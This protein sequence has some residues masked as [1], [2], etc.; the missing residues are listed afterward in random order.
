[1]L[2]ADITT[3]GFDADD[4]LWQ[5]E[6]LFKATEARFH[7]LLAGHAPAE[8]LGAHLLAVEKRNIAIYGFG[9]KGFM[10]SMIET[11]LE[12]TGGDLPSEAVREILHLGHAMLSH[13]VE[14]L[15]HVVETLE[16]LAGRVRLVLITKGDLTD[17]ERKLRQSG[18][19]PHFS[20]VE[21]VSDKSAD[22]YRR[23][24]DAYG[25][26]PAQ[27]LMVGN[28]L[29]SDILPA[30]AAGAYAMHVP[31]ELTWAYEAHVDDH[32]PGHPRFVSARDIR[33]VLALVGGA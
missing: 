19:A 11:A 14:M 10:L 9:V 7:E 26:G 15:P 28:S 31:H 16:A 17:Q 5:N 3:I 30:L 27:S 21:I 25:D 22:T 8:K 1:M 2:H 20:A 24:F 23:V 32:D 12:V 4:T 18:L 6:A 13:P 33:D 29:R